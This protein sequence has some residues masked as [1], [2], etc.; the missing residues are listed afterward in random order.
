MHFWEFF[1]ARRY[2]VLRFKF[3][4][5]FFICIF[6]LNEKK[7]KRIYA[8]SWWI[9]NLYICYVS[10]D[11]FQFEFHASTFGEVDAVDKC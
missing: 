1:I 8:P 9:F 7:K 2:L 5:L 11:W 6:F 3:L 10:V 4:L